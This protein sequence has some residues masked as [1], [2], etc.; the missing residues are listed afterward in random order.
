[1]GVLLVLHIDLWRFWKFIIYLD[2]VGSGCIVVIVVIVLCFVLAD[3][4]KEHEDLGYSLFRFLAL[5]VSL[6]QPLVSILNL[7][8]QFRIVLLYLV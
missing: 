1:M 5:V 6:V 8:L 4:G 2:Y 3:L 7:F